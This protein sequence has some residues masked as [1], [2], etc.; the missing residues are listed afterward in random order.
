MKITKLNDNLQIIEMTPNWFLAA[1]VD[2]D[3]KL[4]TVETFDTYDA[5]EGALNLVLYV[6]SGA[7]AF[8]MTL[9][10]YIADCFTTALE[11]LNLTLADIAPIKANLAKI[12]LPNNPAAEF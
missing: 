7:P 6:V 4:I 11:R 1:I 8:G 5:A 10:E 3:G 9:E 2:N 12:F